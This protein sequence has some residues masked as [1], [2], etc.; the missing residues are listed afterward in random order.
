MFA[1]DKTQLILSLDH[2]LLSL[3]KD[4]PRML[5]KEPEKKP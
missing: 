1:D 4:L 2:P 5:K 3:F